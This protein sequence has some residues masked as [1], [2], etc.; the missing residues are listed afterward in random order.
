MC[1]R[2]PVIKGDSAGSGQTPC[3]GSSAFANVSF[4]DTGHIWFT[5]I[6]CCSAK[7]EKALM[8]YANSKGPDERV[9]PCSLIRTFSV[10]L[11]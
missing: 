10:R 2:V 3:S 11:N 8:P 1:A 4:M 6:T 7:W 5:L 9:H